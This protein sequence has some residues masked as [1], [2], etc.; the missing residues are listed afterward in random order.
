[1]SLLLSRCLCLAST[2]FIQCS[3]TLICHN[4]FVR[5]RTSQTVPCCAQSC[6]IHS[7]VCDPDNADCALSDTKNPGLFV[8]DRV[9]IAKMYFQGWFLVD[10]ISVLPFDAMT[11]AINMNTSKI[12]VVKLLRVLRLA[13]LLRLLKA[14]RV[15]L[16]IETHR[17]IDYGSVQFASFVMAIFCM[18]HWLACGWCAHSHSTCVCLKQNVICIVWW[19]GAMVLQLI[20]IGKKAIPTD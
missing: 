15:L 2:M 11:L 17:V 1:M 8:R 20:R 12:R 3:E 9:K 18:I 14:N 4:H 7:R 5:I 13:K 19:V 10:L 16:Y 6:I